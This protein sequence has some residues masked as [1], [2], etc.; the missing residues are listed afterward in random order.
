MTSQC[1]RSA[2]FSVSRTVLVCPA[3]SLTRWKVR[4]CLIGCLSREVRWWVYSWTTSSPARL[5]VLVT[6]TLT[7]TLLRESTEGAL[8]LRLEYRKLVYDR[9]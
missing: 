3:A 6:S 4:S 9:P 7:S 8:I 2:T 5:P 1:A